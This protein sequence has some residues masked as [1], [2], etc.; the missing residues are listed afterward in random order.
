MVW[1]RAINTPEENDHGRAILYA[2]LNK[3]PWTGIAS[4]DMMLLEEWQKFYVYGEAQRH[5]ATDEMVVTV[6]LGFY[7][8]ELEIGGFI[9]LKLGKGIDPDEL[10]GSEVTYAGRDPNALW[11]AEAAD[12]IE[13]IRKSNVKFE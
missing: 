6:H 9:A 8:Q 1:A 3:S 12:R 4:R 11:R 13:R 2:Q 7:E 10:P 5:F